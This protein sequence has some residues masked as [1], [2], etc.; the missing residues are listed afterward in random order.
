MIVVVLDHGQ[1]IPQTFP[2]LSKGGFELRKR[3]RQLANEPGFIRRIHQDAAGLTDGLDQGLRPTPAWLRCLGVEKLLMQNLAGFE[4]NVI[5]PLNREGLIGSGGG[6][7]WNGQHHG[8]RI[9]MV[10]GIPERTKQ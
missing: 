8:F 3:V 6:K 7:P 5:G 1:Q 2:D 4:F 9:E 10:N